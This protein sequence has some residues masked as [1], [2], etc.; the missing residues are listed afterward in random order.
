MLNDNENVDFTNMPY[1]EKL[2][3]FLDPVDAS[4]LTDRSKGN[5][6]LQGVVERLIERVIEKTSSQ[7]VDQTQYQQTMAA[8]TKVLKQGGW[9]YTSVD[10]D[11]TGEIEYCY[12][13]GITAIKDFE[14]KI[15][16]NL[17]LGVE[18]F[19]PRVDAITN[20]ILNESTNH[21][22]ESDVSKLQEVAGEF[23]VRQVSLA[24]LTN[25]GCDFINIFFDITGNKSNGIIV[26][27]K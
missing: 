12:T 9:N 18:D 14:V 20:L 25:D 22:R 1:E 10:N 11:N 13:V 21:I 26:T 8:I 24:E 15:L 3:I 2:A 5:E 27:L 19:H 7:V 17:G 23:E 4:I 16:N 6:E